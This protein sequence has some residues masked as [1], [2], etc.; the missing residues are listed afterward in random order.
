MPFNSMQQARQYIGQAAEFLKQAGQTSVHASFNPLAQGT[1]DRQAHM[2]A[3]CLKLAIKALED[4][5]QKMGKSD[6]F[7]DDGT[8]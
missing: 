8:F 3:R 4:A 6:I 1:M 2:S 7:E 5:L